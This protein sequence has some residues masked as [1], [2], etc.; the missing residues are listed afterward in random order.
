MGEEL[1][2]SMINKWFPKFKI[3][4]T[5]SKFYND[6]YFIK[7]RFLLF[8]YIPATVFTVDTFK[9]IGD[10]ERVIE[11]YFDCMER[12]KTTKTT[13]VKGVSNEPTN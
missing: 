4:F 11:R 10:A 6:H 8:F 2:V 13:F 12:I 1:E 5:Q 3:Y 9:T 7:Q